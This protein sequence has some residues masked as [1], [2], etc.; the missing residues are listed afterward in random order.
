MAY[1]VPEFLQPGVTAPIGSDL[2]NERVAYNQS[3]GVPG[4]GAGQTPGLETGIAGNVNTFMQQQANLPFLMNLPYFQELRS[5]EAKGILDQLQGNLPEDVIN[6]VIRQAAG[7]GISVGSPGSINAA[8]LNQIAGGS[9]AMV[10]SGRK[11]LTGAIEETPRAELWNPISLYVPE[12]TAAR[13]L[14]TT[15]ASERA[16]TAAT[17]WSGTQTSGLWGGFSEGQN[18]KALGWW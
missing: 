18:R 15:Q 5:T 6:Q 1:T 16:A 4:G 3:R 14:A 10:E 7:R 13:E 9:T 17:P 8:L 12:R 11:A 2:Y